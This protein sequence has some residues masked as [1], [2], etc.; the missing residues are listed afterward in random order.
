MK[1]VIVRLECDNVQDEQES[2]WGKN[3]L[4]KEKEV[5]KEERWKDS[6]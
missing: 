1:K 6:G 5:L 2:G 3:G 4:K